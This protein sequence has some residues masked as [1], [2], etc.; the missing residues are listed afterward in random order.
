MLTT[1]RNLMDRGVDRLGKFT[2]ATRFFLI[3]L[4][5]LLGACRLPPAPTQ[6][7]SPGYA[8]L[9]GDESVPDGKARVLFRL[10][11]FEG[12]MRFLGPED[13]KGAGELH[14]NGQKLGGVNYQE[15]VAFD[16]APGHYEF[17]WKGGWNFEDGLVSSPAI[18]DLKAG[19]S[20][21]LVGNLYQKTTLYGFP[22]NHFSTSLSVCVSDCLAAFRNLKLVVSGN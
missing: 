3:G 16:L 15:Y 19:Q 14:A 22:E 12:N 7:A 1:Y 4:C 18:V 5:L 9:V 2:G 11:T 6:L 10:G 20:V 21:Y 17:T 8:K 13:V